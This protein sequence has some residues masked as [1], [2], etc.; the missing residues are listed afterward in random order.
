MTNISPQPASM[1]SRHYHNEND[2]YDNGGVH[3]NSGVPNLA[4]YKV[5]SALG[6]YAWEGLV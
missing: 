2:A 6:G 1:T 5:A 3:T 4:F